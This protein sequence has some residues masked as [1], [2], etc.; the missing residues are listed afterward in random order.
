MTANPYPEVEP[1][2]VAESRGPIRSFLA[3][4]WLWIVI[5]FVLVFLGLVAVYFLAGGGDGASPFQYNVF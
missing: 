4:Y 3:E 2:A 5:P 1:K